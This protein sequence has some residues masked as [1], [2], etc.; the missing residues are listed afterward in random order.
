[1]GDMGDIFRDM[2]SSYKI[3]KESRLSLANEILKDMDKITPYYLRI[4][5]KGKMLHYWPTSGKMKW[6]RSNKRVGPDYVRKLIDREMNP[7]EG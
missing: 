1:M 7:D 6:G 5:L 2:R 4:E 3:V